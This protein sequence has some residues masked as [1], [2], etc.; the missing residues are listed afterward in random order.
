M[1]QLTDEMLV[2]YVDGELSP[3]DSAEVERAWK[4]DQKV[5]EAVQVFR[6]SAEWSRR[7]FDDVLREPVPERLIRAASGEAY[8]QGAET[9]TPVA[10]PGRPRRA[11]LVGLAMAA[12]IA[13]A[14]GIGGGYGL[15]SLVGPDQ[16]GSDELMLVGTVDHGRTLH[17]ALESTAS[18]I[19]T[20]IG[21]GADVMPLSTFV[22]RGG[23]YCREFQA[24]L[25]DP[26]GRRAAFGVACR[27]PTGF[28]Q[29]EAVVAAPNPGQIHADR[30]VTASG[31][32]EDPIQVLIDAM[33]NTGPITLDDEAAILATGWE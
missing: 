16:S 8:A 30:F 24:S 3:E 27:R 26:D 33:S 18:G 4:A 1:T 13:L 17:V 28:W 21:D 5:R 15:S 6:D 32:A 14:I 20:E 23:R 22:D 31:P 2:A 9:A 19:L 29:V 10:A 12:S 7:A 25:A 11:R